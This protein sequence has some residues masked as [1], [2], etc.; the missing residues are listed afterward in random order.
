MD[1]VKL[2]AGGLGLVV[3]GAV[4]YGV[5]EFVNSMEPTFYAFSEEDNFSTTDYNDK[6]GQ[7]Y[8]KYLVGVYGNTSEAKDRN[9]KWWEWSYKQ[10]QYDVKYRSTEFHEIFYKTGQEKITSAYK[11]SKN[12]STSSPKALNEVCDDVYKKDKVDIKPTSDA[13]KNKLNKNLWKYCSSLA[14][15]LVFLS[16]TS[17]YEDG[18]LGHKTDHH[19][20]AV[21]TKGYSGSSSN[22]KFWELKNEE[23]F[24]AG[25][26]DGKG[27]SATENGIFKELYKKKSNRAS[28]DTIKNTCEAAYSKK[29]T[30]ASTNPT[31][32]ESDIKKFC[33]LT[34][35]E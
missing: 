32:N 25:E 24:G 35:E 4:G 21:A 22:D 14:P 9:K 5:N 10:Y 30:E 6:I 13:T 26:G 19:G 20:K 3:I 15:K 2:S 8:G 1:P 16:D 7:E 18:K 31:V 23:F 34:S 11:D 33:Y 17:G 12:K 29:T 27:N 28:S